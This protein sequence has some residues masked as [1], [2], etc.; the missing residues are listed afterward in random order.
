MFADRACC[1][2]SI[3]HPY[4][5]I[6]GFLGRSRY[7]FFQ[8]APQLYSRGWVD[9]VPDPLLLRKSGGSGNR[10]RTSG[11]VARNS[12]Y[13]T[14]EAGIQPTT[15]RLCSI[16]PQYY[17]YAFLTSWECQ[18]MLNIFY[19]LDSGT[20]SRQ[21]TGNPSGCRLH[22]SALCCFTFDKEPRISPDT[23]LLELS[24]KSFSF[25]SLE[26]CLSE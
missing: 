21:A 9:P 23:R 2:V 20:D 15:C 16:V 18:F 12:D 5:C 11:S 7:V 14:T 24:E 19:S 25:R 3:T 22:L 6:F 13:Q 26:I 10:T 8:V 17:V 1:V 4:G